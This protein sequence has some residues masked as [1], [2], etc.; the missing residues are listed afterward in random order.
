MTKQANR[1]R[2]VFKFK[3]GQAVDEEVGIDHEYDA[4]LWTAPEHLDNIKEERSK[5]GDVYSYGIILQE[6]ITRGS[7]YSMYENLSAKEILDRVKKCSN[8]RFR[9]VV[10]ED[11]GH[12]EYHDLMSQ[13][14]EEAPTSRPRFDEIMKALKKLNGGKNINIVDN[15]IKMMEKYTDHLEELVA[16][17]TKQLEDEK[18]K[19][20]ELLYRMLPRTVAEQLKHGEAVSAETFDMVTIFFSDIVGFTKLAA[21]ST[22]MQV[23]DL[24]N[25]LYTC[26]DQIVDQHHVYKVETIG[27]AYMVVSGLPERNGNRHAGEI[28]R[29]SLDLLSATTTFVVRHKKEYR[30]QLRIGIHSGSCVAGVVG[31]KMPRYCLFG[32]TVNYASR[33][34]SSGLALR[35]HVSPECHEVLTELGG[36]HLIERG[37][38]SMKGKGTI[39][40]Y[41]LA[42][43]DG[44]D[45][46]L[47]DLQFAA[48]LEEHSFK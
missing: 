21:E 12:P 4:L 5:E 34:E 38:V 33:M 2:V 41:F 11:Y 14:W 39:V 20:D 24:L 44:F 15:M 13:C 8:P 32:D 29:M 9:P 26:F 48:G 40:T 17:R 27:D 45:K 6:I 1:V 47:P 30:I 18:A 43:Y 46:T 22:P 16:E 25:D 42:G 36:Y 10:P 19:T 23:V 35:I 28:A 31:L 7:P 37:P 3:D